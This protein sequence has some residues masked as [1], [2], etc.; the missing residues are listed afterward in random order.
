MVNIIILTV[1]LA[2]IIVIGI[3]TGKKVN[4]IVDFAV[5]GRDYSAFV[6]FATLSASFIGGGFSTGNAEK[7]FTYGIANIFFLF[8]FS[9]QVILVALF[10]APKMGRY[11][12]A[13]TTGD[14]IGEHYGKAAKVITGFLSV[15]VCAGILG[16]QVGAMGHVF[17]VFLGLP[18]IW[19]IL[20]GCSIVILYSTM[21][22]MRAV[23]A[24]DVLQFL[25][26]AVGI[27]MT[28]LFSIFHAGGAGEV[29]SKVPAS[30]FTLLADR[31]TAVSFLSLF[32]TFFVGETLVPPYVQRLLISKD[33]RITAKGTFYSGLFSIPFFIIAGLI[34]L[35]ALALKPDLNPNHAMPYII[36]TA[37]PVGVSGLV[38]V[39]MI[40][41]IMSSADSFLNSAA[42]S[43]I[44]DIVLVFRKTALNDRLQLNLAKATNLLVGVLSVVF[45]LKIESVLEILVYSYNFWA[46]LIL[47]PLVS[48]ILGLKVGAKHFFAG[49]LGG[50]MLYSISALYLSKAVGLDNIVFGVVGN[51]V[52]F[53]AYHFYEKRRA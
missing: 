31:F 40:S 11:K 15:I 4:N 36:M 25:I 35:V 32:L 13:I 26:L 5:A 16:A 7:V 50:V 9:L 17:N 2:A 38:I 3:V 27:P 52:F 43:I 21:G 10:V 8:G 53:Y 23:V 37:L 14:I 47:V 48:A 45:A 24:T 41:I 34:G 19:G 1:Y 42:V 30:H 22:G 46:P 51:L 44:N 20:I 33:V 18:R 49:I 6:I 28:L 29:L 12:N 39:A